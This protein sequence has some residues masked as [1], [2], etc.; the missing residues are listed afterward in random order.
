M[1]PNNYLLSLVIEKIRGKRADEA[2]TEEIMNPLH[3]ASTAWARCPQN[4]T[5]GSSGAYMTARDMVK[6]AWLY[7][8]YGVYQ[9][10]RI[11]SEK[12]VK[13]TEKEQYDLYPLRQS[14]FWGKGGLNG[15]MQCSTA[16][17]G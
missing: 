15:Q 14:G 6:L 5:I 12:W 8:N 13:L 11:I 4:H 17:K 1:G 2:I 3:F 7:Q 10:I 16:K 9:G